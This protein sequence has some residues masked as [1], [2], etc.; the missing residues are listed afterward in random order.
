MATHPTIYAMIPYTIQSSLIKTIESTLDEFLKKNKLDNDSYETISNLFK[1]ILNIND[2]YTR[3]IFQYYK[4]FSKNTI[5]DTLF[6]KPFITLKSLFRGIYVNKVDLLNLPILSKLTDYESKELTNYLEDHYKYSDSNIPVYKLLDVSFFNY[7]YKEKLLQEIIM[8]SYFSLQ[9]L[10][11]EDGLY[12][13][14]F[15]LSKAKQAMLFK[16]FNLSNEKKKDIQK[17]LSIVQKLYTSVKRIYVKD[18]QKHWKDPEDE[19]FNLLKTNF[20][21]PF[22]GTIQ[23]N[24]LTK[25]IHESYYQI[26]YSIQYDTPIIYK[27]SPEFDPIKAPPSVFYKFLELLNIISLE[28][29]PYVRKKMISLMLYNNYSDGLLLQQYLNNIK[30]PMAFVNNTYEPLY[31]SDF[32]NKINNYKAMGIIRLEWIDGMYK[33]TPFP[34]YD[35][36]TLQEYLKHTF[37]FKDPFMSLYTPMHFASETEAPIK[38]TASDLFI[39]ISYTPTIQ[40][41]YSII[42]NK[43]IV[44][45]IVNDINKNN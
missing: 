14:G 38:T 43:M 30:D 24:I 16:V 33:H 7:T 11:N 40:I 27:V 12:L 29:N 10:P 5:D 18:I 20:Y 2:K 32:Y 36:I 35:K 42:F 3:F 22:Q 1:N 25:P 26:K 8:Y 45:L 44:P 23:T 21:N 28:V 15:K 9:T 31:T 17:Y 37:L 34:V 19:L 41:I 4:L 6:S 13:Y 39:P